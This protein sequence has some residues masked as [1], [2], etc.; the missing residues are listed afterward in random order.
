MKTRTVIAVLSILGTT[1]ICIAADSTS[2]VPTNGFSNWVGA[3][4]N[5]SIYDRTA[6]WGR[7]MS[8]RVIMVKGNA[9]PQLPPALERRLAEKERERARER[10]L[11]A[12]PFRSEEHTSELQSRF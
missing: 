6:P 10:I 3:S 4:T 8:S 12:P 9:R 5:L 2:S 11:G 1:L 7:S